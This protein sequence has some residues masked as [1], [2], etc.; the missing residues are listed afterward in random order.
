[1]VARA[2][3]QRG[4][5]Q[6]RLLVLTTVLV[7]LLL[8]SS[9]GQTVVHHRL[10]GQ[11]V[12]IVVHLILAIAEQWGRGCTPLQVLAQI[13]SALALAE[14]VDGLVV[15]VG[16][17]GLVIEQL[18]PHGS[19]HVQLLY[20]HALPLVEA[21]LV[22]VL[23]LGAQVVGAEDARAVAQVVQVDEAKVTGVHIQARLVRDATLQLDKG[24]ATGEGVHEV[25]VQR[26]LQVV[27]LLVVVRDDGQGV[28][29]LQ[30]LL[31]REEVLHV[32]EH[33]QERNVAHRGG[34]R[35]STACGQTVGGTAQIQVRAVVRVGVD[36]QVVHLCQGPCVGVTARRH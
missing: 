2:L 25:L 1:M 5:G 23:A 19:V 11:S 6:D 22:H 24:L 7:L 31:L 29:H 20:D 28:L 30:L 4:N 36:Q 26:L 21:V 10:H 16:P 14:S 8:C 18:P 15:L 35:G 32:G 33:L 13:S 34:R 27:V 17:D 9:V 3:V 12:V